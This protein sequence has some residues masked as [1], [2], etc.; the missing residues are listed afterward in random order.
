MLSLPFIGNAITL[1]EKTIVSGDE[2]K[3]KISSPSRYSS[4]EVNAAPVDA[5]FVNSQ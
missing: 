5:A 3:G 4:I 2:R 1:S